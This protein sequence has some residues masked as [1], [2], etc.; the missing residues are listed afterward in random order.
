MNL[1]Q[2]Q[3]CIVYFT[4]FPLLCLQTSA[5][6][7]EWYTPNRLEVGVKNLSHFVGKVQ[8]DDQGGTE[9]FDIALMFAGLAHFPI[10]EEFSFSPELGLGLPSKGRD[11][12]IKKYQF[13]LLLPASYSAGQFLFHFGPGFYFSHLTSDGGTEVLQNGNTTEA[14]FLP[15][16]A[17]TARNFILTA[18]ADWMFYPDFL[19]KT[20]L[21]VFNAEASENRAYSY[22]LGLTYNFNL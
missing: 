17:T 6:A 9:K 21:F 3:F 15:S 8:V 10:N 7:R 11:E 5:Q 14:F 4:I 18:G 2:T 13:Y 22:L 16:G 12:N 1:I 19:I 20:Q